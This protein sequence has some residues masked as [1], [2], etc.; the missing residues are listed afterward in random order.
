MNQPCVLATIKLNHVLGGIRTNATGRQREVVVN[1]YL[2]LERR[3]W[4]MKFWALQ[5]KTHWSRF[6]EGALQ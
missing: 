5:E 2:V 3:I 4:N 6:R 1:L